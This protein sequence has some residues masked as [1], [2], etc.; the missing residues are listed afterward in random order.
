M[1][2]TDWVSLYSIYNYLNND[3]LYE[4]LAWGWWQQKWLYCSK[5]CE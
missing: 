4:S 3:T 5:I 2:P 1:T